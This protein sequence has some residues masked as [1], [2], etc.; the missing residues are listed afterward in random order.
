MVLAVV[1]PM[2]RKSRDMGHPRLG[3]ASRKRQRRARS[4]PPAGCW[5][6]CRSSPYVFHCFRA[7]GGGDLPL[8]VA[9]QPGIGPDLAL[10]RVGMGS[11][12][13]DGV[14]AAVNDGHV[15]AEE[16]HLRIVECAAGGDGAGPVSTDG[17]LRSAL[18][19][20]GGCPYVGLDTSKLWKTLW[21]RRTVQARGANRGPS[22]RTLA[23]LG[24]SK[25]MFLSWLTPRV[26]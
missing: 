10:L 1:V 8:S 3:G 16:A 13:A 22:W 4:G 17:L 11:V 14:L 2:S 21:M 26:A 25:A 24:A 23:D 9:L 12:F 5:P 18:T 20:A 7:A 19:G 15:F 6:V